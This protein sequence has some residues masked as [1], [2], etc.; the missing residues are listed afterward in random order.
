M[1]AGE[2]HRMSNRSLIA[3]ACAA[4]LLSVWF[5][6]AS[7]KGRTQEGTAERPSVPDAEPGNTTTSHEKAGHNRLIHEKSPYLLQHA[8]NPV[9]WYPWGEEAFE[10]AR[11]EG[12]PVFLSIG[13]STCHWCHVMAHESFKDPEVGRRMNE[14]FVSIK[15]DRE[16]RPDID[17]IYMTVCQMMT[18]QGGWPLTVILTPEK[19]PFFAGTYFPREARFGRS[20]ILELIASI[21]EEWKTRREDTLK[22]AEEITAA[23]QR[24]S[25][26]SPGEDL[27]GETLGKAYQGL[28]DQFDEKYGGFGVAPKFPE[29][30]RLLFMLRYWKRTGEDRA[31]RMVEETLQAMLQGGIYDQ[32]GYGFHRY[33]TDARWTVPHFEKMLYDQA[34]LAMA[35]TEAYQATGKEKYARTA[36]EIFTYVLRDMRSPEGGFYAAEDAD[37]E[38]EEGKFYLWRWDE[39]GRVLGEGEADL[40][41]SV[42]SMESAG[43]FVEMAEGSKLT[44]RWPGSYGKNILYLSSPLDEIAEERGLSEESL[45]SR[46]DRA[47][48][49]LFEA[50]SGRIH[51]YKD[52]KILADWNG[53]MI[54]ALAKAA[55]ALDEP[56]YAK[57]AKEAAEFVLEKM[58]DGQGR[59]LHRHR[60]GEAAIP[61]MLTDYAFMAWG[62]IEL[63]EATF[64]TRYLRSALSLTEDMQE[65]FWDEEAG[66]FFLVP[67]DGER[68]IVRR[69]RIHD[70][71]LPSGNSVAALNLLR[72]GRM[73]GSTEF[74]KNAHRTVRAFSHSIQEYPSAFSHMMSALSFGLGPNHEVII[75]GDSRA[76]DTKEMVKALGK[77]YAPNMVV[78]LKPT[79]KPPPEIVELAPYMEHPYSFEGRATAY[80]CTNHLCKRPTT[81]IR[82]ML[83][84]MQ[85]VPDTSAPRASAP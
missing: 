9:D 28:S 43:N 37:S 27:G 6:Q 14:V 34:Q 40:F 18:G 85:T 29:P 80:V 59:L 19:K 42:F 16:E 52:D 38:G 58:R 64:E 78:L 61:A 36:T 39:V 25:L 41:R 51:P 63:Y 24:V 69:K 2:V 77:A 15:V 10:K 79:E 4:V 65:H 67:D 81:D 72:L 66:G 3:V 56:A 83:Q 22:S 68:Q 44:Q 82:E 75:V 50:R 31:L 55:R 73:T 76:R 84:L 46:I 70:T 54:A 45:G 62:M 21:E 8:D 11:R 74:E 53:L 20:G 32:V 5:V 1:K 26:N 30:S 13:Y 12:K 60:E 71:A 23:L 7:C 17:N 33:A 48:Q 57:A 35:Y 49:K 47:R